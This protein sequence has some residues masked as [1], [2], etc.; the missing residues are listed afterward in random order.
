[1]LH[2]DLQKLLNYALQDGE[3]SNKERELLH[4]KANDLGE[5]IDLLE[6]VIE[7]E[8]QKLKKSNEPEK[9]T[10]FAC[11]NCGSSIPK[12]S[13]KC[14]FCG[15]EI[16]KTTLT[17]EKYIEK[18]SQQLHE[19]NVWQ[20]EAEE[21]HNS[22][23]ASTIP[24]IDAASKK[25]SLISVFAMPNDKENLLELFYF[26][27][28][29]ADATSKLSR[30]FGSDTSGLINNHLHPAWA[31]KAKMA[32]NKLKRFANE[33]DEIKALIDEYKIKYNVAAEDMKQSRINKGNGKSILFG[34]NQQGVILFIVLLL[35]CFPLCW[36][37]FVITNLKGE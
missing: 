24:A 7:G 20:S 9:Q 31:G 22:W 29:N 8:L 26:C 37:P 35:L 11:P 12:S 14:G 5:D 19:I 27:D 1:M 3:I 25:A 13:I 36:L 30:V 6:M 32:Y 28:N 16:S 17:G 4:K 10:N 2:P 33:D 18:L 21:K 23:T 15:F 34:L